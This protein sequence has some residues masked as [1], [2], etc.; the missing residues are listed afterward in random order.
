MTLAKLEATELRFFIGGQPDVAKRVHELLTTS[1]V[2]VLVGASGRMETRKLLG[3]DRM[4][5]VG[6][7]DADAMLPVQLRMM[8]GLRLLQEYFA[9]PPRFLFFDLLGLRP[10]LAGLPG[11]ELELQPCSPA[12]GGSRRPVEAANFSLHCVPAINLF[13][14]R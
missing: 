2:G 3:A 7:D 4:Q 14:K 8:S 12:P 9:F 11:G 13:A 5:P 6:F 1:L 10:L